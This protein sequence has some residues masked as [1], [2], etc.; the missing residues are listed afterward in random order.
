MKHLY[1]EYI[2]NQR[3]NYQCGQC[4]QHKK[5]YQKRYEA[6]E[7]QEF[8]LSSR[9]AVLKIYECPHGSGYHLTSNR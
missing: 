2:S 8:A 3:S 4:G 1:R 7:Q 6:Q 5:V 9:G